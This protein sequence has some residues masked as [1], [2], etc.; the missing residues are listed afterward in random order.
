EVAGLQQLKHAGTDL[1]ITCVAHVLGKPGEIARHKTP[2]SVQVSVLEGPEPG[3]Q[4]LEPSLLWCAPRRIGIDQ[5]QQAEVL[6]LFAEDARH[7]VRDKAR[8]AEAA[9]P[10]GT[11]GLH[12]AHLLDVMCG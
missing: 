5:S 1:L 8:E 12:S 6:T 9:K 10:I 4:P 3:V 11:V 2:F 7:L